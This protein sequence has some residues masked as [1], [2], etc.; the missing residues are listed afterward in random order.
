MSERFA[1]RSYEQLPPEVRPL[2]D[3][4]LKVSSAGL[5]GPYN[6]LLRSP[7][8]ARRCF[9]L[10]DYLRFKTSVPKALNEL[11]ILIQARVANA[12]YEWWAHEPIAVRAGLPQSIA[13]DL[14]QCKRPQHMDD[15]HALVYDFCVQITL[16]HQVSDA[17]WQKAMDRLGEQQVIDL[18]VVS[19]TY[20]M[21]SMLLNATQVGIPNHGREPLEV[22]TPEA[23][24]RQLLA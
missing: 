7:D 24:R 18:I 19:G 2:A 22:M 3:D 14:R 10:L 9:D 8:M 20:T 11:A 17:L 13:D 4:I 1:L 15:T 21:V 5:G 6:A 23:I 16:N 12:Q